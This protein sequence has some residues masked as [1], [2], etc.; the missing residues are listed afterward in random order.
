MLGKVVRLQKSSKKVSM[1]ASCP[2]QCVRRSKK[3]DLSVND[4]DDEEE[5]SCTDHDAAR[6]LLTHLGECFP[7]KFVQSAQALDMPIHQ[8]GKMGAE[9][10]TAMW[11]DAGVGAGAQRTIMKHFMGFFGCKFAAP[12]AT[13]NKLAVD[14]VP[15]T[16]GTMDHMD[17][18]LD[19]WCKDLVGLLTGQIGREHIN[20]QPGFSCASIDFVIGAEHGQGSFRASAKVACR[21]ANQSAKADATIYGLGE[22]ECVK[23]TGDLLALAFIP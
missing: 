9:C 13:T 22:T 4:E 6:W 15:P 7:S 18:T 19:C 3:V 20:Q 5:V 17:H 14:S 8:A 10:T 11:S 2:A 1:G 12:K 21:N 16:V 23:D